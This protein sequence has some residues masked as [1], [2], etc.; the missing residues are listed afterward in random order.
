MVPVS[1]REPG[2]LYRWNCSSVEWKRLRDHLIEIMRISGKYISVTSLYTFF[3][4]KKFESP[5]GLQVWEGYFTRRVEDYFIKRTTETVIRSTKELSHQKD[6]FKEAGEGYFTMRIGATLPGGRGN[7]TKGKKMGYGTWRTERAY[8][9]WQT[10]GRLLY[11]DDG[12][13]LQEDGRDTWLW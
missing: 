5:T 9:R 2:F 1:I 13:L 12:M 11:Q 10:G 6:E 3:L 7:F 8:R 4:T